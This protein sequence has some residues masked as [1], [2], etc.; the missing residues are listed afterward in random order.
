MSRRGWVLFAALAVVWG[1]PYLMIKVAVDE[2]SPSFLVLVRTGTAAL[3]LLP[4]AITRGAHVPALRAW[5]PA[6]NEAHL[7][8]SPRNAPAFTHNSGRSR[9]AAA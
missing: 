4:I 3:I 1:I 5:R 8:A 2:V 9:R 6:Y 7:Q